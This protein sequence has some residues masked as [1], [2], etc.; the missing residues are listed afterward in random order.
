MAATEEPPP[1]P[2]VLEGGP[3]PDAVV[4]PD[5]S[6]LHEL[7]D[8]SSVRWTQR[9]DGSWRK[10]ERTRAGWAGEKPGGSP[11]QS[12]RAAP[13][14]VPDGPLL[15]SDGAQD[16]AGE[17]EEALDFV[18]MRFRML[19]IRQ[20]FEKEPKPEKL[21]I[22]T[23]HSNELP[24]EEPPPQPRRRQQDHAAAS[25]HGHGEAG[26]VAGSAA[27]SGKHP[28]NHKWCLWIH[29]R[30]GPQ[31]SESESS[32]QARPETQQRV[33]EFSTAEDYW[34]MIHFAYPPSKLA[35]SDY[36]LFRHQI[37]PARE[38]PVFRRGGGRWVAKLEKGKSETFDELW[39]LVTM[40]LIGEAFSDFGGD[41][42]CGASLSVRNRSSRAAL[43]LADA[44]RVETVLAI[45]HVFRNVLTEAP[46]LEGLEARQLT[47]EYFG[48]KHSTLELSECEQ[49]SASGS[50]Q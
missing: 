41:A 22:R 14:G 33:H 23:V 11:Q 37:T 17:A 35:N 4:Q 18:E 32:A 38:D 43:W 30:S 6:F 40:A 8:G 45:G 16:V 10:P 26:A 21:K 48:R 7:A 20:K 50:F 42:I 39:V 3:P 47:F 19:L 24:Y 27:K 13:G 15:D 29:Q 49:K 2:E 31:Q 25:G 46:G 34:C 12:R 44:A 36:S 1:S 9:P 5:G 28:L